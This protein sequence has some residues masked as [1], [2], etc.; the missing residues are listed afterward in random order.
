M[1]TTGTPRL[2]VAVPM[3]PLPMAQP[4]DCKVMVT[5]NQPP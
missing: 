5:L 4:I 2:A 1:H 3:L